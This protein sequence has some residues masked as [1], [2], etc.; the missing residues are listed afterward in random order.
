MPGTPAGSPLEADARQTR[1]RLA[2]RRRVPFAALIAV[3]VLLVVAGVTF[4]PDGLVHQVSALRAAVSS[5]RP[6][7]SAVSA[8]RPAYTATARPSA[9]PVEATPAPAAT[10][11]PQPAQ[12]QSQLPA[13][14]PGYSC[15]AQS[16]GGASQ[17]TVTTARVGP[18]S[19]Y[20][21]FVVQFSG[22]VPQYRVSLQDGATFS[23]AGLLGSAGL[24]VTLKNTTAGGTYTGP[25]DFR[26]ALRVIQEAKLVSDSGGTVEWTV[27]LAHA[28][29]FHAWVLSGPSR[30]VVDLQL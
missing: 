24:S 21:R 1:Q 2:G 13:P 4:G 7:V 26:P 17:S 30:L 10:P 12:P 29:C 16:G 27:G 8:A 3:L 9:T 19:G 14:L 22:D 11:T 5:Q 28:T 15:T 23:Q 18:Q 6:A 25:S 20:D